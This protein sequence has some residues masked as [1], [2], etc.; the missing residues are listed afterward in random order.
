MSLAAR[1]RS[2]FHD[3][4]RQMAYQQVL[5]RVRVNDNI[6]SR[7]VHP[8]YQR[9]SDN[10]T[11]SHVR[12]FFI[13]RDESHVPLEEKIK[14]GSLSST[15]R[16]EPTYSVSSVSAHVM[17]KRLSKQKPVRLKVSP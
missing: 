7:M 10:S 5:D 3:E 1:T 13:N 2:Q 12:P 16:G 15:L 9:L 4:S 14:G 8:S 6:G 11:G 17:S